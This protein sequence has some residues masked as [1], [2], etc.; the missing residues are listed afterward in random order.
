MYRWLLLL[1]CLIAA[2]AGLSVG[3]MNPDPVTLRLPGYAVE[4]A[5]GPLIMLVFVAGTVIGL[6]LFMVLFHL[7][8]RWTRRRKASGSDLSRIDE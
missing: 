6:V 8:S 7:P 5:L 3:V 4:L 2:V 1:A